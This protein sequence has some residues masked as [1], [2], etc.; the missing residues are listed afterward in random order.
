MGSLILGSAASALL[1]LLWVVPS[2]VGSIIF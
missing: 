2:I 1:P